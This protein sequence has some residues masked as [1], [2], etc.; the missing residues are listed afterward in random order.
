MLVGVHGGVGGVTSGEQ[1]E[2]FVFFLFSFFPF[3][4]LVGGG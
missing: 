4:Y 3:A 1:V 2:C